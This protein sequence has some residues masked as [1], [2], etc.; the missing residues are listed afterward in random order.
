[1]SAGKSSL[2]KPSA[3]KAGSGAGAGGRQS[4]AAAPRAIQRTVCPT[5]GLPESFHKK[6]DRGDMGWDRDANDYNKEP[7]KIA[8]RKRRRDYS[9]DKNSEDKAEFIK[10]MQSIKDLSATSFQ[11]MSKKKHKEEKLI[12]LGAPKVKEQTMPFKMKMGILAGR[13]KREL[14]EVNT[15]K[16]SGLIL[17][18]KAKDKSYKRSEDGGLG[19][20]VH[21]KKGILHLSKSGLG[22]GGKRKY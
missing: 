14:R 3:S 18:S 12:A 15:A 1:M 9:D 11:G 13:K 8:G 5:V 20:D 2:R 22:G 4:T 7:E 19:L 6:R 10:V 16:E 17:P 21:T